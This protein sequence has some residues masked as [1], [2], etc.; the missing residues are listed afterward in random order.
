MPDAAAALLALVEAAEYEFASIWRQ[1]QRAW[2]RKPLS[3]L[4]VLGPSPRIGSLLDHPENLDCPAAAVRKKELD[5]GRD[6]QKTKKTSILIPHLPLSSFAL[7][8]VFPPFAS[9]PSP[10]LPSFPAQHR[11]AQHADYPHRS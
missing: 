1:A 5:W 7:L 10:D 6:V 3:V 11:M 8:L 9:T 4:L 2:R